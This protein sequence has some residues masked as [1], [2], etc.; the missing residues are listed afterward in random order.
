MSGLVLLISHHGTKFG[1]KMLI[2][3]QIIAQNEIQNGGC[4]HLEFTSGGYF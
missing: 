2:D 3:A 1:A 4:R